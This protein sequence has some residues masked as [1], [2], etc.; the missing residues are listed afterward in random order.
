MI[1]ALSMGLAIGV[2]PFGIYRV[3]QQDWGV[4]LL[5]FSLIVGMSIIFIYVYKTN[6]VKYASV[7]LILTALIVNVISF[8]LKGIGQVYWVFP[9][10]LSSYYVMA[11]KKALVINFV[12]LLFFMPKLILSLEVINF[13]TII[14]TIVI[15]NIIAY[16]FASGLRQQELLLTQLASEDY[17]TGAGNR[18]ALDEEL[19]AMNKTLNNHD[20]T[21]TIVLLDLDYFKKVN[22]KFGHI[23]GDR[24]LIQLVG[25][26]K[27][28][29]IQNEKI[30]RYGGEEFLI[31]CPDI[32]L[33]T[34]STQADEFRKLVKSSII[35]E[36]H[37]LTISLG[38]AEYIKKESNAVW[39]HRVDMALYRAKNE[40]RDRVVEA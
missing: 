19:A 18:R 31:V 16:V 26:L 29:Y 39:I 38:V 5:D 22:D 14:V 9:V 32:S 13:S 4:A 8:Y 20:K 28:F 7:I 3:F 12:M 25:L 15:T 27:T 2:F 33:T 1:M 30:F 6:D 23:K 36:G 35:I 24:V 21:A 10:V 40:G 37:E 17:L 11:A 34:A